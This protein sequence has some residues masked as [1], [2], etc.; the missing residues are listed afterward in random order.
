MLELTTL[1]APEVA[2]NTDPDATL[3]LSYDQRVKCR[4][5]A[6]LQS[7]SEVALFLPR[8][9]VLKDGDLLGSRCGVQV[10]VEAAEESLSVCA[11]EDALQFARACYHLGNRHVPLQIH[12]GEL[13]YQHD[14]VLDDMLRGLGLQV[15]HR[16]AG[17]QPENGAYGRHGG[18]GHAH[19]HE[20]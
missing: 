7:G 15:V 17:F 9:T 12:A 6:T 13:A 10:R 1:M 20:H 5:R 4:L 8:G 14:H 11:V 18:H 3:S 2:A 19:H 16:R